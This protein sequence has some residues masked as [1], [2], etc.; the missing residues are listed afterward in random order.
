MRPLEGDAGTVLLASSGP[1]ELCPGTAARPP[2]L[3][4]AA[5]WLRHLLLAGG[6]RHVLAPPLCAKG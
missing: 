5:G 3:R 4:T 1:L 2:D 6:A